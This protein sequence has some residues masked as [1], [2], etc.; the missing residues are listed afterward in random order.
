MAKLETQTPHHTYRPGR[1]EERQTPW[2]PVS[3]EGTAEEWKEEV[4]FRGWMWTSILALRDFYQ[5]L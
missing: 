5:V 2:G 4:R 1:P 3:E